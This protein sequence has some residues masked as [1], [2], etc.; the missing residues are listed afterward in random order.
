MTSPRFD[1][2]QL[3]DEFTVVV[4]IVGRG[5][6]EP[7]RIDTRRSSQGVHTKAGIVGKD[8]AVSEGAIIERFL[9]GVGLKSLLIFDARGQLAKAGESFDFNPERAR[10]RLEFAQL[11]GVGGGEIKFVGRGL[12]IMGR[13]CLRDVFCWLITTYPLK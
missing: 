3:F 8:H 6:S 11:A 4:F 10:R 12:W 5:P 7:R 2:A 9:A 13:Q 1:T